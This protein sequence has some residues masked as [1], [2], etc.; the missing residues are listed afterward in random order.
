MNTNKTIT[1]TIV[2]HGFGC[3]N[4]IGTLR[5]NNIIPSNIK[6]PD[7]NI[8]SDPELT[9]MGVSASIHNG[10][11]LSTIL[12]KRT[13]QIE[14]MHIV[15]CSPL[16]RSMETAYYMTRKWKNPPQKIFVFP[17]LREID[18]S[19]DD[20]YS[21]KSRK[22]IDQEPAYAMK[23][24]AEQK[25]Y[26]KSQGILEFFDFTYVEQF[27]DGRQEPGDIKQFMKWFI[28]N[29]V[30]K[31]RDDKTQINIFIVTHAGVIRDFIDTG[32]SN[33]SGFIVDFHISDQKKPLYKKPMILEDLFPDHFFR[34]YHRYTYPDLYC[35]SKRCGKLCDV[36]KYSNKEL[37]QLA[38]NCTG[39]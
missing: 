5:K 27:S 38:S 23:S 35:P 33:N 12:K 28:N 31:I 13:P 3:H 16:I 37:V 17:Y 18:E 22:I 30:P 32:V 24:I 2:R 29:L 39:N 21:S 9:P 10:C 4:A 20:K 19:S 26:L 1:A 7:L 8:T 14:K 34:E 15:G 36:A 6:M 11:I 25:E